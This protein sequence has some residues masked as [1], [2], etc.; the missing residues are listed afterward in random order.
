MNARFFIPFLSL[1]FAT[2]P[3]AIAGPRA[4]ANYSSDAEVADA[5]GRR[6]ASAHY[7]QSGSF[8][9]I[10]GISTCTTP[11]GFAKHGFLGQIAEVSGLLV[12]ASPATVNENASRQLSAAQLLDDDSKVGVPANAVSWLAS[13]GSLVT[14]GPTGIVNAGS[15]YE[16]TAATTEGVYLGLVGSVNLTVLNVGLDDFGGY[17]GDQMDDAWQV[18]YFGLNNPNAAPAKDPDGDGQSNIFEFIA[19]VAPNDPASLFQMRIEPVADEPGQRNVVFSPR[20]ADRV[21]SLESQTDLTLNAW[22]PLGGTTQIDS[23]RERTVT[24][25]NAVGDAKFYRVLITKP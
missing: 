3:S 23:G 6:T 14:V 21:Y 17:A 22:A 18:Q 7:S 2:V 19:G 5:G 13:S 9:T 20:F 8:G 10:A 24:D 15:V 16:H 12:T 25:L 4:S 1:I 11:A